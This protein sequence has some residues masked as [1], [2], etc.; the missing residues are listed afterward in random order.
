MSI[1]P[2]LTSRLPLLRNWFR[3]AESPSTLVSKL[4]TILTPKNPVLTGSGLTRTFGTGDT[5]MYALKD[6]AIELH[7][8]E[9][10][11]LMGPSGSGKSTLLAVLSALLRP[12][13]GQ[14]KALGRDVWTMSPR[15]MEQFRLEHCSYIFQGY[16]LFPAFTAR[17]QLEVVLQW[18]E[19]VSQREARKRADHVLGQLGLTH[20]AHLRPAALSGGEKQRVA[21]ARALVKN[22]SFIFA[23]EPTSALDWENGQAVMDLL[24]ECAKL[25]GATVLVVAHDHRL[26]SYADKI[27]RMAD[28]AMAKPAGEL[29]KRGNDAPPRPANKGRVRINDLEFAHV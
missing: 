17:Q 26:E 1:L 8:G 19:G 13:A 24:K 20:R 7:S 15:E 6:V 11:L 4:P 28:G 10:N 14:V 25:R 16:N 18:G 29:V 12:N 21:I 9:L 5:K 3:Q 27:F 2:Q 22:P 23:D